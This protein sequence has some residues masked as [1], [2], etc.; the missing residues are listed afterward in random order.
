MLSHQKKRSDTTDLPLFSTPADSSRSSGGGH[1]SSFST[2]SSLSRQPLPG[3]G[4][5]SSLA[6]NHHRDCD[7]P[8]ASAYFQGF[9]GTEEPT[10]SEDA[11]AH[12]AYS[13][14]LRRH[15]TLDLGLG[16][17][18][19]S[20]GGGS[21]TAKL[22]SLGRI[23]SNEGAEFLGR[24]ISGVSGR[25][26]TEA[27]RMEEGASLMN[28]NGDATAANGFAEK[29]SEETPSSIFAHSS[30]EVRLPVVF[31]TD[32]INSDYSLSKD[33]ASHFAT[34]I[35]TGLSPS[36]IP[37]LRSIHGYNEFSVPA[38]EHV[39]IKFAK[40]IFEQPL[41]LLLFGSA[42]V[43]AVMHNYDD[44]VSITIAILIVLTGMCIWCQDVSF[45]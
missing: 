40:N 38:P 26:S 8:P 14:T 16:H 41:I 21:A 32:Y 9:T 15:N 35:T 45:V 27:Y 6:H 3:R 29:G 39:L 33:T 44:A 37:A 13:T 5:A 11:S 20:S 31:E 23:V 28:G 24:V 19:H 34:S 22:S 12:F 30:I 2:A 42:I 17:L 10:A 1:I 4:Y 25:Q 7:S 36:T 18:G 43:S